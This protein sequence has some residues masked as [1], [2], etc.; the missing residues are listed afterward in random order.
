MRSGAEGEDGKACYYHKYV[1]LLACFESLN[2]VISRACRC[3][4]VQTNKLRHSLCSVARLLCCRACFKCATCGITLDLTNVAPDRAT[5]YCTNHYNQIHVQLRK[6][7]EELAAGS[8]SRSL[9]RE[10]ADLRC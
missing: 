9:A 8:A 10:A 1:S 2:A 5:L 3:L 4:H 7:E 6:T